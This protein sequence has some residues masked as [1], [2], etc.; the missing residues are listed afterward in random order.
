[1]YEHNIALTHILRRFLVC[2]ILIASLALWK[3]LIEL[4][5]ACRSKMAVTLQI[6]DSYEN[7]YKVYLVLG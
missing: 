4:G 1:M 6:A 3:I 2:L 5:N 7:P